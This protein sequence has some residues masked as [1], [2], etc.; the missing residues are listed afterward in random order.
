MQ[1]HDRS[2][3]DLEL[4]LFLSRRSSGPNDDTR[5]IALWPVLGSCAYRYWF[6]WLSLHFTREVTCTY[7]RINHPASFL[8][9]TNSITFN[10]LLSVKFKLSTKLLSFRN[11]PAA[12]GTK[13]VR[14]CL[15]S[16]VQISAHSDMKY[17]AFP[18]TDLSV[19]LQQTRRL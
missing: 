13:R 8:F 6:S 1:S 5:T 19:R 12:T 16:C 4:N 9:L 10:S 11:M 17:R 18:S 2:T 3:L 15:F 14:V 7:P